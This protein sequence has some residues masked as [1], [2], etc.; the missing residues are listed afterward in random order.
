MDANRRCY[1]FM[2]S[3]WATEYRHALLVITVFVSERDGGCD[4]TGD[5]CDNIVFYRFN[6]HWSG[7][8]MHE[9]RS[10]A[11]IHRQMNKIRFLFCFIKTSVLLEAGNWFYRFHSI[12]LEHDSQLFRNEISYKFSLGSVFRW[13]LHERMAEI[14]RLL[15]EQ[16]RRIWNFQNCVHTSDAATPSSLHHIRR[17]ANAVKRWANV[18]HIV[19]CQNNA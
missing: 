12:E 15:F 3:P 8:G 2:F 14:H 9:T 19:I 18:R 4:G 10:R 17:L 16:K 13:K 11:W 1:D 7:C 5:W 6:F